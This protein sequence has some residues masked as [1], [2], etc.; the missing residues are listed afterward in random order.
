MRYVCSRVDVCSRDAIESAAMSHRIGT[1]LMVTVA[2]LLAACSPSSTIS[3]VIAADTSIDAVLDD[4]G[5]PDTSADTFDAGHYWA[6]DCVGTFGTA[7][8]EGFGRIDGT[9]VAIVTPDDQQCP[10]PNGTHVVLEVRMNGDVYR[11]VTSSESTLAGSDP[12]VAVR[13][14]HA[15]LPSPAF[16]EGWH[17]DAP[18]GYATTLAQHSTDFTPKTR[19]EIAARIVELARIG[20]PVSV[21]ATSGAGR[22]ESAHLVHYNGSNNDGA[23]V[24]DP[25]SPSPTWLLFRFA[26]QT[27]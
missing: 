22:P 6:A 2:T 23:I 16:A 21:Y 8:T 26:D 3:D 5:A 15:S 25:T 4:G 10:M 20:Q 27:F 14:I 12:R 24:I 17:T 9:L 11:L 19:E 13:E 1:V 18:L 7:L